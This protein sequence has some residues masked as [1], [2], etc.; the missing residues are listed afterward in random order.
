MKAGVLTISDKGSRG[1][2]E[3]LSGKL[4]IEM[5][6]SAGFEVSR[7][8][9]VPDEYEDILVTL[10]DWADREGLDLILT[11]GGTGLSPRDVTP[12]ATRAA[13]EREVP[14]IAEAIRIGGLKYTPH[15]MLSRGLAGVRKETLIINLPGS[16]KAVEEAW[17]IIAPILKHAIEKVK[18]SEAEC[19]RS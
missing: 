3:D 9:I 18:G 4:L 10:I 17:E 12:E 8:R 14:G 5:L 19:A 2:R 7:Y 13:I 16:P 6:S 11:T 15:A 1:E